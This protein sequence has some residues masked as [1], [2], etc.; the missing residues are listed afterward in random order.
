MNI[1][2]FPI[3]GSYFYAT[4]KAIEM[5]I[6]TPGGAWS[7]DV[8]TFAPAD[9]VPDSLIL[10]TS[11]VSGKIEGDAPVLRVAYVDDANAQFSAEG[12]EIPEASP[13]LDEATIYTAKITQLLRISSEQFN[14]EGAATQLATSVQR[15]I[16]KKANQA[17]LTQSAPTS[18]S[19]TPPAGL[20][21]VSGI[22]DGG[23]VSGALDGLID[24]IAELQSNGGTQSAIVLD[25]TGWAALRKIKTQT[26]SNASL[27]GAGTTDAVPMLL[28][29]PVVVSSALTANSGLVLDQTAVVS[30]VGPITV[31][32][33]D[34]VYF[35][36]DAVALR[37]TW[38][39]G[40]N[41]VHADRIGKFTLAT[42]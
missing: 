32:Q 24:L 3:G 34:Q 1:K 11:T 33:S 17:Y 28:G 31:A 19:V 15:A 40:W 7:P 35:V 21:N 14:Q 36:S 20:A 41:V 8:T 2:L 25:P 23:S 39:I 37:A 38:R 5:A 30:A 27:L 10:T 29:I 6:T 18:P 4:R 26:D 12:E 13:A 42:S 9:V 16:V 22:I